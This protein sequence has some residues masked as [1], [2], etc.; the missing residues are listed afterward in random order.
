MDTTVCENLSY[1]SFWSGY[2]LQ[3]NA[4][5]GFINIPLSNEKWYMNDYV[6]IHCYLKYKIYGMVGWG[7][8]YFIYVNLSFF[9]MKGRLL[10]ANLFHKTA[11]IVTAE[12]VFAPKNLLACDKTISYVDLEMP[13]SIIYFWLKSITALTKCDTSSCRVHAR[14][15]KRGTDQSSQ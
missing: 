2:L 10:P 4:Q 9:I 14:L 8:M 6:M 7:K 12:L 3:W 15:D 1:S 13:S 11:N 5:N